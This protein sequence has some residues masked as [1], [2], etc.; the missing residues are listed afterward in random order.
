M[1]GQG[2]ASPLRLDLIPFSYLHPAF[3]YNPN[4][5]F[6]CHQFF[7]GFSPTPTAS[8]PYKN[9]IL[10]SSTVE[11]NT[12]SNPERVSLGAVF[13][14]LDDR[15]DRVSKHCTEMRGSICPLHQEL[16]GE[17]EILHPGLG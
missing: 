15:K 9:L 13:Y 6:P 4:G 11:L 3:P 8:F 12:P 10:F 7:P 1:G 5:L 14:L 17:K 2:E 16:R